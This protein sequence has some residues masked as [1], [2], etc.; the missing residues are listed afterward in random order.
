[1][2]DDLASV[3]DAAR[4]VAKAGELTNEQDQ[5]FV[6]LEDNLTPLQ[7]RG[8]SQRWRARPTPPPGGRILLNAPY[9][10]QRD[11][12]TSQGDRMCFSSTCAMAAEF[13]RPGCLAGQGQ[14]DDRYL[15]LVQRRG[16]TTQAPAQV[17][18]LAG[19]G[20]RATFRQ[21]GSLDT[22][23]SLLRRGVPVPVG[24]LHRGPVSAPAGGG[25]WSLVIGWDPDGQR[26]IMHD[27][28]GEASLAE[29]G[30]RTTA[31]GSGRS[32]RYSWANW[33]PRWMV[34]GPGSGW[35]LELSK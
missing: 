9:F 21:D 28:Y 16:D 31:V 14:P 20:I 1:M 23:L 33:A 12:V 13:L 11:S 2:P 29:G 3:S 18:T 19:L 10:S 26:L 34:E 32:V 6:W 35:L 22:L 30:Y 7:R 8:F 4:H 25:H 5:A 17:A 24:W 27:P 15:A